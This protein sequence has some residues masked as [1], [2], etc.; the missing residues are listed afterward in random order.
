ELADR[1]GSTVLTGAFSQSMLLEVPAGLELPRLE[2]AVQ[3]LL[4]HH[5]VLRAR[6][7]F[8]DG[9]PSALV[10]PEK[11][12]VPP[13]VR[14]VD[15]ADLAAEHRIDVVRA[16]V[17]DEAKQLD[18]VAGRMVRVVWFDAG[19]DVPGRVLVVAHHLAVDGVSWRVLAPDLAAAYE[20]GPD[21][22][23]D[24][25]ASSFRGWAEALAAEAVSAERT[26]E[27]PSWIRMLEGP[28]HLLGGRALDPA[29]DTVAAG[30]RR[31]ELR[32]PVSV[33]SE[34]LTRVPGAFHAGIDD[35]LLAALVAAVDEWREIP[36]GLLVDVESHGRVPLSDDMDLTRTVGWFTS[37]HPLRL[38]AGGADHAQ[39]R[40][41]GP[42]AGRLLKRV[43]EQVRAVPGDG[44]GLGYGLLRYLN[45]ATASAFEGFPSARIGFNYLGRFTPGSGD[46]RGDW[47]P[48][49]DTVLGGT[50]D[51][52]MVLTHELD[53]GGLVRDLPE[54][55][56]LTISLACP[57]GLLD[58]EELREL[59]SA[60]AAMLNGLAAHAGEPGAGGHTPSDFPLVALG[61]DEVEE[62]EAAVP[63]LVDVWPLS[64]LQEGLLFHA[65]YDEGSRDVYVGQR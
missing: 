10:V 39:V 62:L 4:D 49:G 5:D 17:E 51:E 52:R 12:S 32:V 45:P 15:A 34:L 46:V 19:P 6:L 56:E 31:V 1:S 24:P 35:V 36:G 23:L 55:P 58:D 47:Q 18:P 25:V 50:A 57:A 22:V 27:L 8:A 38:D 42:E 3:R 60:W 59:T 65:R 20:G 14:R 64:P 9:E 11:G 26:A 33:T 48:D 61:Q 7:E 30:T 40:S 28:D 16:C 13:A 21:A 54:G 43:K 44:D 37:S 29:V 63:G 41:G 53:A 2:A